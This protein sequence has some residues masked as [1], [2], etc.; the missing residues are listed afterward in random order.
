MWELYCSNLSFFRDVN[1][2]EKATWP[3]F[4]LHHKT[5]LELDLNIR[6]KRNFMGSR[7]KFWTEDV[8]KMLKDSGD[9]TF[10]SPSGCLFYLANVLFIYYIF[11]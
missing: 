4:D 6:E 7:M 8:P 10:K 9:S 11:N 2:K 3:E 5:Y 1:G